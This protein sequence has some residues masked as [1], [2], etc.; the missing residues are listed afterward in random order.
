[1]TVVLSHTHEARASS[2]AGV[3]IPDTKLASEITELVRDTEPS[4]PSR[5]CPSKAR[6]PITTTTSMTTTGSSQAICSG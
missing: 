4:S 2:V 6:L 5:R 1:M 3:L